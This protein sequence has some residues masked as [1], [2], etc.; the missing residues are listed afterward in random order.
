MQGDEWDEITF[1]PFQA[2]TN[3]TSSCL[4]LGAVN[5]R[6]ADIFIHE[7]IRMYVVVVPGQH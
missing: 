3:A 7:L 4:M 2:A 6:A 1:G 5:R